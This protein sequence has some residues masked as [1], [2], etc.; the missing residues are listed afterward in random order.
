MTILTTEIYLYVYFE[1]QELQVFKNTSSCCRILCVPTALPL[2]N[3]WSSNARSCAVGRVVKL[4]HA[5]YA[6][7]AG[8]YSQF[9]IVSI[10]QKSILSP[11]SICCPLDTP[12]NT[13]TISTIYRRGRDVYT[14]TMVSLKSVLSI[15]DLV[16]FDQRSLLSM[17]HFSFYLRRWGAC[18]LRA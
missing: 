8:H 5:T 2:G 17:Y 7:E 15:H 9:I 16:D 10:F 13:R 11:S 14:D 1:P 18:E 12:L 3:W 6:V 4:T